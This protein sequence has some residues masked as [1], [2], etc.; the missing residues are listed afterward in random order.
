MH[1]L[2]T[3]SDIVHVISYLQ[4]VFT[5]QLPSFLIRTF[6]VYSSITTSDLRKDRAAF[7]RVC[8]LLGRKGDGKG[9]S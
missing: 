2:Q 7:L 8:M 6:F 1:P 3:R 5:P 4:F 9:A